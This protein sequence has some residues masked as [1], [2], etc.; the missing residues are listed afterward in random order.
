MI[1]LLFSLREKRIMTIQTP[2]SD[3]APRHDGWTRERKAR[4]LDCLAEKGNVR[5][6]CGRVGLSQQAAYVVRRRDA[7]FARGWAAALALARE[8]SVQVLAERAIDGVEEPVWYRG[9]F[10]GT[11][12]KYDARLLLAHIARLD[13]LVDQEATWADAGRFDELLACIAGERV[14]SLIASDDDDVLPLDREMTMLRAGEEADFAVR[15]GE[16]A[17]AAERPHEAGDD[18]EPELVEAAC[19]ALEAARIEA[20]RRGQQKGAARWDAWFDNACDYVDWIAGRLEEPVEAGL[21]GGPPLEA[22]EQ[23]LPAPLLEKIA[24]VAAG[25]SR[26]ERVGVPSPCTLSTY[27]TSALA[28]VLA[29]PPKRFEA[30]PRSPFGREWIRPCR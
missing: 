12:R 21:P 3:C 18:E 13:K 23:A 14:A 4:F 15:H 1:R 7:E 27:S 20:F 30:T 17:E 28:R 11:R 25:V 24:S 26:A 5:V 29:G 9:E 10:V 16:P 6:A 8:N 19:E 2:V 22:A